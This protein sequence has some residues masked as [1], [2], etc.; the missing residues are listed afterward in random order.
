MGQITPKTLPLG[1]EADD[2]TPGVVSKHQANQGGELYGPWKRQ[3]ARKVRQTCPNIGGYMYARNQQ[4]QHMWPD[5]GP[6]HLPKLIEITVCLL[7]PYYNLF[8]K[9]QCLDVIS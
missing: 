3:V 5:T 6:R 1:L 2:L 9:D 7:A 4:V 8:Q